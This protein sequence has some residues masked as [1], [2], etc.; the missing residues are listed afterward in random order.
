MCSPTGPGAAASPAVPRRRSRPAG[1]WGGPSLPGTFGAA[2]GALASLPGERRGEPA[3]TGRRGGRLPLALSFA[4][5]TDRSSASSPC[6]LTDPSALV[7]TGGTILGSLCPRCGGEQ[8][9]SAAWQGFVLPRREQG[10]Q[11][12]T[13]E[14]SWLSVPGSRAFEVGVRIFLLNEW[15]P[16][17]LRPEPGAAC[18]PASASTIPGSDGVD[19][20]FGIAGPL[21][22]PGIELPIGGLCRLITG[23]RQ[24]RSPSEICLFGNKPRPPLRTP[25]PLPLPTP[26]LQGQLRVWYAV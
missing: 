20:T 2:A 12:E 6:Q 7:P 21:P 4:R 22:L 25:P 24:K 26:A 17:P 5:A 13:F 16:V 18:L 11:T 9:R 3:V 15:L 1:R 10:N 14:G 23:V 19:C 8:G